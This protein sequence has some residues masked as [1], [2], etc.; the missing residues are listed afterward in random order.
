MKTP[1]NQNESI[2]NAQG[3]NGPKLKLAYADLSPRERLVLDT[4]IQ[5]AGPIAL[6]ALAEICFRSQP[7][8]KRNSWV[9]NQLRRLV[10]AG[11]VQAI[12]PGVYLATAKARHTT[13]QLAA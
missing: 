8:A 9:R 7:V 10:R 2:T 5:A 1:T 13:R 6:N 3:Q 4:I 11:F 12:A